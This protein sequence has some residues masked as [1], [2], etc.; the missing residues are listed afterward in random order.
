MNLID[1]IHE[2]I[3]LNLDYKVFEY[4]WIFCGGSMNQIVLKLF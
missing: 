2:I 4:T 1:R 3:E